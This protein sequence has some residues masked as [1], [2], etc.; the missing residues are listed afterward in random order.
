MAVL[1]ATTGATVKKEERAA[2]QPA[3]WSDAPLLGRTKE[4]LAALSHRTGQAA[5]LVAALVDASPAL[6][7]DQL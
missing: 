2:Q 5:A 4:A 1:D 3:P 7:L 6:A